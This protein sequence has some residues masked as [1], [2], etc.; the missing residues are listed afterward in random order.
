MDAWY[1][2]PAG[3]CQWNANAGCSVSSVAG[4]WSSNRLRVSW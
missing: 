2:V 3:A 1:A 4:S